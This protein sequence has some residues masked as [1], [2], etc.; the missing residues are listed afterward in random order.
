MGVVPMQLDPI[1]GR[2][3][4]GAL[5]IESC[6]WSRFIKDKPVRGDH[7]SVSVQGVRCL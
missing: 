1:R 6:T 4:H 5:S 3:G 7:G 2:R